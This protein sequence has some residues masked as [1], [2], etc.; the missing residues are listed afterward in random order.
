MKKFQDQ[1]CGTPLRFLFLKVIKIVR[2]ILPSISLKIFFCYIL[3]LENSDVLTKTYLS[4]FDKDLF[5]Q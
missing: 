5:F 4:L 1:I 2:N 3:F